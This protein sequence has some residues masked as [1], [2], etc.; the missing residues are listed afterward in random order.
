MFNCSSIKESILEVRFRIGRIPLV[1]YIFNTIRTHK[2]RLHCYHKKQEKEHGYFRGIV[3]CIDGHIHHGGF[4]DRFFG[5]LQTYALCKIFNLPF[6]VWYTYPFELQ[7]FLL[8]AGYNWRISEDNMTWNSKEAKPVVMLGDYDWY[9]HFKNIEAKNKQIYLYANVHRLPELNS[10]YKTA[11]TYQS[12]Y[13]ELFKP[14]PYLSFC[15]ESVQDTLPDSYIALCFRHR[16]LFGDFTEREFKPLDSN[17]QNELLQKCRAVIEEIVS[18]NH[19]VILTSDSNMFL[20]QIKDVPN[21]YTVNRVQKLVHMDYTPNNS[22]D[23]YAQSFIDFYC[24]G[25]GN[26]ICRIGLYDS[27][28][29]YLASLCFQK[30]FI[31]INLRLNRTI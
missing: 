6:K 26:K 14:S 3:F 17:A 29:P 8:P 15:L 30:E 1:R 16:N 10:F 18:Q 27:G 31:N 24:L 22:K 11:F 19:A 4:A 2:L 23:T 25:G 7:D 5:L 20:R 28:F 13:N 21:V 12:L 9:R